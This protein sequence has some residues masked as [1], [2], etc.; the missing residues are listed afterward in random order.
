M[1][2]RLADFGD[3]TDVVLI[4][5]TDPKN[6]STYRR[7]HHI[8]TLMVVDPDRSALSGSPRWRNVIRPSM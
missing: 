3:E 5:F 1:R 4:T 8:D 6:L 7:Q 2:D